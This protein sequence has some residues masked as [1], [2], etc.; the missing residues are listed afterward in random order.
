MTALVLTSSHKHGFFG[1]S[2]PDHRL[3]RSFRFA[4]AASGP[5]EP[6]SVLKISSSSEQFSLEPKRGS[7][8]DLVADHSWAT[9]DG[10]WVGPRGSAD[11]GFIVADGDGTQIAV[12]RLYETE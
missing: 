6:T 7:G 5:D 8:F 9:K 4:G 12:R 11:L 1:Q 3:R 2:P 10:R